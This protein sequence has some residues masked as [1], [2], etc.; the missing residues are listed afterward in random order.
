VV[1]YEHATMRERN[2]QVRRYRTAVQEEI[3]HE[4]HLV[5]KDFFVPP[6][7]AYRILAV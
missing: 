4:S 6:H 3:A 2:R 5:K 1:D 7:L